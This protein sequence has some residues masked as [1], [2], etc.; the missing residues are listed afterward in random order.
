MRDKLRTKDHWDNIFRHSNHNIERSNKLL[1]RM[2]SEKGE[3]FDGLKRV[4]MGL[5]LTY[6]NR[7]N[8]LYSSGGDIDE[9]NALFP[10]I[11]ETFKKSWTNESGYLN[12]VW[13]VS[14]GIMI[15]A[16]IE[17]MQELEQ[18]VTDNDY[19][20]YLLNFLFR[21]IDLSWEK[22]H[23][24]FIAPIPYKFLS[25]VIEAE[26]KEESSRL[27]K[28][29]LDNV[30]Y[31]GHDDEFWYDS[32]KD[33]KSFYD[34]YWSYESGAIAKILNLDDTGWNDMNYYPYDMVHY[35]A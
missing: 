4:Y 2:V 19:N 29:Y 22:H 32:H 25:S 15:D 33:K 35:R 26:T 17:M 13:L 7:L 23:E 27:L 30:W 21:S 3:D 10:S 16:P 5:R 8:A 31:N 6:M 18:L 34:G 20:D 28:E 9:I 1:A 14:I 11:L 12:I 24:T